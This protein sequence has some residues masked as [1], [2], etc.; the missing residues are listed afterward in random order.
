MLN[1]HKSYVKKEKV[2][3]A[4]LDA[5][6]DERI[7]SLYN[8]KMKSPCLAGKKLLI[9]DEKANLLPCEILKVLHKEGKTSEPELG[10][11]SYGT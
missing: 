10:D 4:C 8:Q 11:F 2:K 7:Q 1:Y 9:I 5:M 3:S 6:K